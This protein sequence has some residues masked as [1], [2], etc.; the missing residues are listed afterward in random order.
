MSYNEF[1]NST[2]SLINNNSE[3]SLYGQRNRLYKYKDLN[4]ISELQKRNIKSKSL[5]QRNI[6]QNE[7]G[8]NYFNSTNSQLYYNK[9]TKDYKPNI[10]SIST[11]NIQCPNYLPNYIRPLK[12]NKS[13]SNMNQNNFNSSPENLTIYNNKNNY[14][15]NSYDNKYF[16]SQKPKTFYCRKNI[17]RSLLES[18][19][20]INKE[21][22]NIDDDEYIEV[23]RFE[24]A[25]KK[26]GNYSELKYKKLFER[27]I[28]LNYLRYYRKYLFNDYIPKNFSEKILSAKKNQNSPKILIDDE[29]LSSDDKKE[30]YHNL[31]KNPFL[32]NSFGYKFIRN[33][34]QIKDLNKNPLNDFDLISKIRRLIINPNTIEFRNE[35]YLNKKNKKNDK[36]KKLNIIDYKLLSKNGIEKI[37]KRKMDK[38][39]SQ[40]EKNNEIVEN[41]KIKYDKLLEKNKRKFIQQKEEVENE[42]DEF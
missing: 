27:K 41:I 5:Y 18:P 10:K 28:P 37:R 8:N 12:H 36:N 24:K 2:Q 25:L 11:K 16:K 42:T 33:K 35:A 9:I 39:E 15:V 34:K 6:Y 21:I 22:S 4:T 17:E 23:L 38:Y 32:I 20:K 14:L 26:Y 3:I 13:L 1:P 31:M 40:L 29:N 30:D 19:I 7:N